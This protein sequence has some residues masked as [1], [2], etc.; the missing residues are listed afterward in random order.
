MMEYKSGDIS[1]LE[2]LFQRY[3]TRIFNFALRLIG[4]VADAE[5]VAGEVFCTL[6]AKKDL[7]Q[8]SGKFSTWIYTIAHHAGINKLRYKKRV[9]FNWMKKDP[10]SEEYQQ[11]D[12]PDPHGNAAEGL[13][14]KD[15]AVLVR[16]A[17]GR[18]PYEQ[19]EALILREYQQLSY[20]E[21]SQSIGCSLEKVKV[22]IFR[23]RER[24]KVELQPLL[25]EVEP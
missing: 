19:K 7:Y 16:K 21:I 6:A 3:K 13:E 10:D 15:T 5:D 18:L 1:A 4:N 17:I 23:A 8:P 14:E 20:Y 12:I 24:L 2:E 22:L 11:W 25:K 9:W